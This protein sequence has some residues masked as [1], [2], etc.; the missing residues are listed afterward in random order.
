MLMPGYGSPRIPV[1]ARLFLALAVSLGITPL[2]DTGIVQHANYEVPATVAT[3]IAFECMAGILIGILGRIFF[4]AAQVCGSVVAQAAGFNI[5]A[6][7]DDGSGEASSELGALLSATVLTLLFVLDFHSDVLLALI[8]SYSSLPF[9]AVL[10][11]AVTLERIDGALAESFRLG[12]RIAGPFIIAGMVINFAFGLINKVAPQVP[13][14]FISVPFVMATAFWINH[15]LAPEI[16][17]AF[18]RRTLELLS[19]G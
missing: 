13:A 3:I 12:V 2:V 14:V 15:N 7:V 1:Q 9:G 17:Q 11:H 6:T 18:A 4:A 5:A 8:E 16:A 19:G 10:D